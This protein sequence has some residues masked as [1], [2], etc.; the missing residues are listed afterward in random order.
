M[1]N[2]D[3]H[4]FEYKILVTNARYLLPK[5]ESLQNVFTEH[6]VDVVFVTESWLRDGTVLGWDILNLQHGTDLKI[7]FRNRPKRASARAVGGGVSIIYK[8][9]KCSMREHKVLGNTVTLS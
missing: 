5:I 9:S 2:A 3:A 1:T 4:C 7:V 6:M 8:K